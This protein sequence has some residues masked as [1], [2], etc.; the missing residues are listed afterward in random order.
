MKKVLISA[1]A[2]ALMATAA[3]AANGQALYAKCAGCH[4]P[5]GGKVALGN[6]KIIKDMSKADFVNA[7]KGYKNGT[8][9]GAMKGVMT[10]QAAGLSEAD[11][12]AIADFIVK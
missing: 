8:Y 3:C 6:S 7:L 9:G 1:A 10:G 5:K 4:G 2:A 12:Q 11:M